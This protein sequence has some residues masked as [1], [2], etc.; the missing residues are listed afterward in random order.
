MRSIHRRLAM[1]AGLLVLAA[2]DDSPTTSG[3]ESERIGPDGGTLTLEDVVTLEFPPDFFPDTRKVTVSR[4]EDAVDAE[5]FTMAVEMFQV[6]EEAEYQV[7]VLAGTTLPAGGAVRA[8]IPLPAGLVVPAGES[9]ELLA[10]IYEDAGME[11]LDNFQIL[12]ASFDSVANALVAD[13]PPY[14]FTTSRRADGQ[15]E[16]IFMI[17]TTPGPGS[18]LG[19]P[20]SAR[21]P[22]AQASTERCDGPSIG[23]PLDP[24]IPYQD[25][26]GL[27]DHPIYHDQRF[28]YGLD[29]R[30]PNGTRVYAAETGTVEKVHTQARGAGLYI[31]LR[32]TNGF[33]TNYFHLKSANVTEGQQVRRGDLIAESD[34]SGG[35][36]GP[37]LHFEYLSDGKD[38][39]NKGRRNP[40][41]CIQPVVSSSIRVGDNGN[42]NDDSFDVYL[43]GDL[44]GTTP[45]GGTSDFGVSNLIP[46]P[47][48]LR[49]VGV[50][51]P[52]NQGTWEVIL[53]DGI[54]FSDGG[55]ARRSDVMPAGGSVTLPITVP[56]AVRRT[57]APGTLSRPSA[58]REGERP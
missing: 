28:H 4:V 20:A 34:N 41:P 15:A 23:W 2:C 47:H 30:V 37:H 9:P 21:Q 48:T 35:S 43:D 6:G 38:T 25:S 40:A 54:T 11:V 1:C 22:R 8:V 32:H 3:R 12:P 33:G 26:W 58:T 46:G 31:T 52:D 29:F 14:V 10:R 42:L 50:V 17:V 16:A 55:G 27:R 18:R 39:R 24:S 49:L 13:L 57:A 5:E 36:T 53:A 19:L 56:N 7:R 44:L 45:I 51:V